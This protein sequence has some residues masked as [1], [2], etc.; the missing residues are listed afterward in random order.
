MVGKHRRQR[1]P[2]DVKQALS[3]IASR[4]HFLANARLHRSNGDIAL[5][6]VG[7]VDG[8][9]AIRRGPRDD[10]AVVTRFRKRGSQSNLG[11]NSNLCS[12]KPWSRH[13]D[14]LRYPRP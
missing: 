14:R 7:F 12:G 5:D 9:Q 2:I 1:R 11:A 4:A 13:F 3:D 10:A 6:G 8:R